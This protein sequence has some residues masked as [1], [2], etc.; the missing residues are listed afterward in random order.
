ML[1]ITMEVAEG[2]YTAT[3]F[4]AEFVSQFGGTAETIAI[5][6]NKITGKLTTTKTGHV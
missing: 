4:I 2:N 3:S 1:W 5:T 6:F